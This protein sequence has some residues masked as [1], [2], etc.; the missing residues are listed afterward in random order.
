MSRRAGGAGAADLRVTEAAGLAEALAAAR[1]GE[2][3]RLAP[4]NYGL[5][6]LSGRPDQTG[7]D[8]RYAAPVTLTS[9]DPADPAVFSSALVTHVDNLVIDGLHFDYRFS[10]ADPIWQAP[11]RFEGCQD[12]VIRN[13]VFDGDLAQGISPEED[14]FGWAIGLAVR[15]CTRTT[16]SG[17][18]IQRFHRGLTVGESSDVVVTG[19]EVT[20]L[21]MDGM[22]FSSMQGVRIEGNYLHDFRL[23]LR[24]GDHCDMI[25]FWTER[26]TRQT[27]DVVIRGNLLQAGAGN[28]TQSI[29]MR[30]ELVDTGRAGPEMFYRRVTIED[31]MIVN[32]H[33]HGITLGEARGVRIQRNTVLR[34]PAFSEEPYRSKEVHIP[35]I[36]L[37]PASQDVVVRGNIAAMLPKP[38]AG[39]TVKDNMIAQD[40]SRLQPGHYRLLFDLRPEASGTTEPTRRSRLVLR[41]GSPADRPGLGSPLMR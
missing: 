19:N 31:N 2:T 7:K 39:W 1:G 12:L 11:F 35:R 40:V 6:G 17:N 29:F 32:G 3:I 16:I 30:N 21:R 36:N 13:S 5:L 33:L 23:A 24:S 15:N 34:D 28:P 22:T 41:P 10:A 14:G 26:A 27:T 4:G 18:R 9:A 25:Q 37:S 8:R 20:G 38:Q